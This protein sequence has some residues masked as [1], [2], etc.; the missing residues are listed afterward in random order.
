MAR[1][2]AVTVYRVFEQALTNVARHAG[3]TQVQV[4]LEQRGQ[5]LVLEVRDNGRGMANAHLAQQQSLG[6]AG[7]QERAAILG[8]NLSIESIV[9]Q[10]TVVILDVPL[11]TP[12]TD[13]EGQMTVD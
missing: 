4:K 8:G 12:S 10:G 2:R 7:M 6:L 5:R 3:A 13:E 9:G 1:T 11:N